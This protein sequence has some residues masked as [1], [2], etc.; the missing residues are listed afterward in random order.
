MSKA[1]A[2]G[3]VA[4][5][6]CALAWGGWEARQMLASAAI[7]P[8][9]AEIAFVG[10]SA[11]EG[12][13]QDRHAS[14]DDTHH[15][16]MTQEASAGSVQGKFSGQ[17]LDYGGVRV[18]PRLNGNEYSFEYRQVADG[19]LI[20]ELPVLRTVGSRRYQQYLTQDP[21]G[22]GTYYRLHYL[23]HNEDQEWVRLNN[24]FLH[25]DDLP[26]DQMV[27]VWDHN[28]IFCHNT[29]PEPNIQNYQE[30]I[31]RAANGEPVNAANEATYQSTVADLGIGCESCHS[32]GATHVQANQSVWRRWLLKLSD[33]PDASIVNPKRLD[34]EHSTQVCG[35]CHAQRSP[36][37]DQ[38]L[39]RWLD[40]GPTYRAGMNLNDHVTP[41]WQWT[42][43]PAKDNPDLYRD[44]FWADGSPRLSAYEYQGLLQ[45]R[46][47]QEAELSC[48]DCHSMHGGDPDGMI[49]ERNRG[50]R[51]CLECHQ[52][53]QQTQ[54]LQVHTR[55][56]TDGP[57]SSCYACHM[58][59]A[60]YGVMT[61]HRT[62]QIQRPDPVQSAE[63]GKPNA[64][65]NC[66][67]DRSLQWVAEQLRQGWGWQGEVVERYDGADPGLADG[68][69]QMLAGDV[70]HRAIAAVEAG[71][72]QGLPALQRAQM[73]PAL[74]ALLSDRYP[75]SRRF[76]RLSL[77]AIAEALRDE[78]MENGLDAAL[79]GY[80]W[81]AEAS[82]RLTH[83]AAVRDAWET[84]RP[85]L[86]QHAGE[87]PLDQDFHPLVDQW[88][89][90]L[91][92]GARQDR[93]ISIGE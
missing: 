74:L 50:N 48:I 76:S 26:F 75:A 35:A 63:A 90:L 91:E 38:L 64:C 13:H 9:F 55:H 23:W 39:R 7:V 66:H 16:R 58:P 27:A 12:C 68:Y 72:D 49:S 18:V 73:I 42:A 6:L 51:P 40:G 24:A 10:S 36:K 79:Q 32:P 86:Q 20:S 77:I 57:G 44:R 30:L 4:G 70:M 93:Q 2:I 92:L 46:C 34:A 71:K 22:D 56:Q 37:S 83:L 14:W 89:V 60:T 25:G 54:A 84:I 3:L 80:D 53:L 62:H 15:S 67:Q 8:D 21:V 5:V 33:S 81:Q 65:T 1:A 52:D 47:Y 87:L 78:G 69:A 41:V 59:Y 11:C 19:K 85:R 17:Q 82:A 31:S 29:G 61:T 88:R 43:S 28:C 45:S